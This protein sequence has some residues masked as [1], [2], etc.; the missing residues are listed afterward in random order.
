MPNEDLSDPW[1]VTLGARRYLSAASVCVFIGIVAV[2]VVLS[3]WLESGVRAERRSMLAER[4]RVA[5][6]VVGN[7]FESAG[8]SLSYLDTV[9]SP[10]A[11]STAA[12]TTAAKSLAGGRSTIAA[13]TAD[14]DHP[15]VIASTGPQIPVGEVISGAGA[16]LVQQAST[17]NDFVAGLVHVGSSRRLAFAARAQ[18]GLVLYQ[19]L[20]IDM[21]KPMSTGGSGNPFSDL[22]GALY[23]STTAD[24]S[25]LLLADATRVPVT[26]QVDRENVD[27]G[28]SHWLIVAAAN[29]PLVGTITA[30]APWGALGGGL[31]AALLA[32]GMIETLVRR[33]R[34]A[35]ALADQR[36]QELRHAL[37]RQGELERNEREA[38]HVA[39]A[40]NRSKSEFLSRMSHE[41]RTPLN[42]V[43]GFGQLLDAED[44]GEAQRESVT[45]IL[46]GGRHLLGLINDVLDI[47]RIETGNLALS[48]EPV[49]TEELLHEVMT[50][51]QPLAA[52]RRIDLV[53]AS[54]A[55]T[56]GGKIHVLA[57]HQRLKQIILN[58]VSN[59]IKYNHPGGS[60]TLS[61]ETT[62]EGRVR[63]I[64]T[65]T[66]PGIP[67]ENR[68]RLFVPFERLGAERTEVEGTGVGL[69]LSRR[70]AEAM[71]G[72]LDV[73]SSPG[74][75]SRF[76]IDLPVADDPL[77]QMGYQEPDRPAAG[78]DTS[79]EGAPRRK[80]LYIEDN[81]PN[82]RLVERIL[83]KRHDVEVLPAMQ[84]RLGLA[85]AEQH[86]P[87]LILL[88]LHLPDI[89]GEEVLRQL[90]TNHDTAAI[91]V[92]VLSADATAQQIERV[93]NQGAFRYLTKPIDVQQFLAVVDESLT[94]VPA[95][96]PS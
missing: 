71:G 16:A 60:V 1:E 33:R 24:S 90:R 56:S 26:G 92:V 5:A 43:L 89:G 53:P 41:L 68:E 17:A 65:D 3:V 44:L 96:Q 14:G 64:V 74:R 51:M 52:G 31:L 18:H 81:T 94:R 11:G 49:P 82:L 69:A 9:T 34:Y 91:P 32:S 40:A 37:E 15:V 95:D 73:E 67:P 21:S 58:L 30:V 72:T 78:A 28:A 7:L 63:L 79:G 20:S 59:A 77:G 23:A 47:S 36:T 22:R 4:T 62:P 70:L 75:G 85:L 27:V 13:L 86:H 29:G 55:P 12:F 10:T 46:K 57:D 45:Q 8:Q 93:V 35:L 76:W 48:V 80:I 38:R 54:D 6:L 87:D 19:L 39:E 50:L 25:Q 42:A 88:D 83:A 84:G 2:S 61:S 66:G